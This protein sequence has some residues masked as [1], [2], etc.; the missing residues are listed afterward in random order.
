M[1]G[2]LEVTPSCLAVKKTDGLVGDQHPSVRFSVYELR[3]EVDGVEV[4]RVVELH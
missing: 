3:G 4:G 1:A 2:G